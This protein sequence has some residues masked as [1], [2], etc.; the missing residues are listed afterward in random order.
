MGSEG[1]SAA[2][3][4]SNS[5]EE[6]FKAANEQP[7][8]ATVWTRAAVH[9]RQD[10]ELLLAALQRHCQRLDG[11]SGGRHACRGKKKGELLEAFAFCQVQVGG[12]FLQGMP[13]T[14]RGGDASPL[15]ALGD[16]VERQ[17]RLARNRDSQNAADEETELASSQAAEDV[18]PQADQEAVAGGAE[19]VDG[20]GGVEEEPVVAEEQVVVLPAEA[21]Q[22]EQ[23]RRGDILG[24][25]CRR[26]RKVLRD[27]IQ[28]ASPLPPCAMH[29]HLILW[30]VGL[31]QRNYK[32]HH[33]SPRTQRRMPPTAD[34]S[35]P[36]PF[37]LFMCTALVPR[38]R[39]QTHQ[40][41]H[42]R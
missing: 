3:S 14:A 30:I 40:R 36:L 17:L 19:V 37:I 39:C 6:T 32:A 33:S 7:L 38:R 9:E 41:A 18:A 4:F 31:P 8:F 2:V 34:P 21:V 12:F 16:G 22:V 20:D 29:R 42:L 26:R 28:C 11:H 27:N 24:A 1:A 25:G 13:R 5:K 15:M 23:P 10:G 35:R